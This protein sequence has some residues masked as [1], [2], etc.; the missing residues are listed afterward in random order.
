MENKRGL[1]GTS[2]SE[3]VVVK[4]RTDAACRKALVAMATAGLG[5][6]SVEVS[7]GTRRTRISQIRLR[8]GLGFV[9]GCEGIWPTM[10]N[11]H[12]A[13]ERRR[14]LPRRCT[15]IVV[16]HIKTACTRSKA[17]GLKHAL[18]WTKRQRQQVGLTALTSV[19]AK[20][21][22]ASTSHS[23]SMLAAAEP[24][25]NASPHHQA[26]SLFLNR[27]ALAVTFNEKQ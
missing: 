24:A 25:P 6:A 7:R 14:N 4:S 19:S 13:R 1:Y 26:H 15:K 16:T 27:A 9:D 3:V 23:I 8:E 21:V 5:A 12:D 10:D 22:D 18:T 17:R 11:F 20:R 2:L